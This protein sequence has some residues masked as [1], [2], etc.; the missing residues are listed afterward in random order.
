MYLKFSFSSHTARQIQVIICS[1]RLIFPWPGRRAWKRK[2]SSCHLSS[3]IKNYNSIESVEITLS[4]PVT[5]SGELIPHR[6]CTEM[7]L[8]FLQRT[9]VML[10][11]QS[12]VQKHIARVSTSSIWGQVMTKCPELWDDISEADN[13]HNKPEC[14]HVSRP[15]GDQDT[16]PWI[17][18]TIFHY[19][20]LAAKK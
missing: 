8:Q 5:T 3:I 16:R 11:N 10:I 19:V 18:P 12:S 20:I 4:S 2:P 7:N 1:C 13:V 9:A 14:E 15:D 6:S 17:I